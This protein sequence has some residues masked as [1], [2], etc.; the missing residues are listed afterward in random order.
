MLYLFFRP[1]LMSWIRPNLNASEAKVY[2]KYHTDQ[3][4]HADTTSFHYTVV[5]YLD[6]DFEGGHLQFRDGPI[7]TPSRGLTVIFTSGMENRHRVTPI[8]AGL[9]RALTVFLT[10]DKAH[11]VTNSL[12]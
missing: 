12:L 8:F 3:L 5:I 10:C 1:I 7:F 2:T 4:T 9:R 6:N 11:S